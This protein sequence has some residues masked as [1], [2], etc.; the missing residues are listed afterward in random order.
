MSVLAE[1]AEVVDGP[2]QS[3]YGH[4]HE[5]HG[6]TAALMAA[7]LCRKYG[8]DQRFDALDVCVFN[9]L[10]KVSQLANTPDHHDSLVDICGYVRNYEM[11]LERF[12]ADPLPEAFRA[13]V[14][15]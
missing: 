12:A 1:A 5:N 2:R 3:D 7:Y 8:R 11:V 9:V 4:P 6:C 14:E 13:C 10:Q 15:G